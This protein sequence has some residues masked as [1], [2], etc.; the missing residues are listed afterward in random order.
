MKLTNNSIGIL[1]LFIISGFFACKPKNVNNKI[2]TG[3]TVEATQDNIPSSGGKVIVTSGELTGLI[4]DVPANTFKEDRN[5]HITYAPITKHDLGPDFNPVSP[6]ITISNGGGYSDSVMVLTIPVHVAADEFAMA[7]LYDE[8]TGRLEGM[9]L[10]ASDTNRVIVATRNF[11]CPSRIGNR[12]KVSPT[13]GVNETDI[14]V[15][16][17]KLVISATKTQ[18]LA[19][20]GSTGFEPGVDDCSFAN[21]GS[22]YKPGGYCSG[23]SQ[24]MIWYYTQKKLHGG[25]PLYTLLD[26]DGNSRTPKI[27]YDDALGIKLASVLQLD[28]SWL[29]SIFKVPFTI[30][31][32]GGQM[33]LPDVATRNALAYAIQV[34][35]EPQFIGMFSGFPPG[36]AMVVYRVKGNILY[37]AD[38]NYP[39]DNTRKIIFDGQAREFQPYMSG[40]NT[41]N[42]GVPYKLFM[43]LAQ[44]SLLSWTNADD[45]WK[46]M[47]NKT[48]GKGKFPGFDLVASNAK[49]E[50]EPFIDGFEVPDGKLKLQINSDWENLNPLVYNTS[51]KQLHKIDGFVQLPPGEQT[52]GVYIDK[53]GSWA[54]FK[55]VKVKLAGEQS[56]LY[57]TG[58]WDGNWVPESGEN[59]VYKIDAYGSGDIFK[60]ESK[61]QYI[62]WGNCTAIGNGN[63]HECHWSETDDLADYTITYGGPITLTMSGNSIDVLRVVEGP[64]DIMWKQ[65]VQRYNVPFTEGKEWRVRLKRK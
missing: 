53:Q 48:I 55:W 32:M 23:Q 24:L 20:G 63:L 13:A 47:E 28:F 26:N 9:P 15:P 18:S 49:G 19:I 30:A 65:G 46:E 64:P 5:F 39:G 14:D 59:M 29:T 6:L 40:P 57:N 50:L 1:F 54:G 44:S 42:L 31:M 17:V 51:G 2:T 12:N 11:S 45:R 21:D 22:T 25:S 4:I 58:K 37:V 52:I 27:S 43:Y 61:D 16:E 62:H 7:F 10:I 33:V 36:H 38:P 41:K 3:K 35:H 8:E 60:G 56:D 34:T